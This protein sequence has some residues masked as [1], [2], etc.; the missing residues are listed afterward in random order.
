MRVR[1]IVEAELVPG[2]ALVRGD[3][4]APALMGP[5]YRIGSITPTTA[6]GRDALM[7]ECFEAVR[8]RDGRTVEE[9]NQVYVGPDHTW[10]RVP[11]P[12]TTDA[13]CQD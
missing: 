7:V 6:N 8:G 11:P 13:T 2:T 10:W 5:V 3:L 9:R 1:M 4:A 12:K